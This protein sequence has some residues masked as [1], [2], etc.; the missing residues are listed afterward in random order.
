MI[1]WCTAASLPP[2]KR[3]FAF[4]Q[5]LLHSIYLPV[6]S[7]P[8]PPRSSKSEPFTPLRTTAHSSPLPCRQLRCRSTCS[9][10]VLPRLTPPLLWWSPWKPLRGPPGWHRWGSAWDTKQP[11][12]L[13]SSW[14]APPFFFLEYL[15]GFALCCKQDSR[16]MRPH[17]D[18]LPEDKT[19]HCGYKYCHLLVLSNYCPTIHSNSD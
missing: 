14:T 16:W 18:F 17:S 6:E 10:R 15:A 8:N 3:Y 2:L 9:P 7:P 13:N 1:L 11:S 5:K 4:F 12:C 19:Q